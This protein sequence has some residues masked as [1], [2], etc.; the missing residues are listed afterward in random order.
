M[1]I[2][3]VPVLEGL[4]E[5]TEENAECK[6]KGSRKSRNTRKKAECKMQRLA[7]AADCTDERRRKCSI[8]MQERA[9]LVGARPETAERAEGKNGFQPVQTSTNR[10][11]RK[12]QRPPN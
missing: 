4:A 8:P 11:S 1:R 5:N 6:C 2:I 3:C 7:D 12:M 9:R 10:P